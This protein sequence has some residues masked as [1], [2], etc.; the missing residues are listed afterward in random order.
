MLFERLPGR[1]QVRRSSPMPDAT[2]ADAPCSRREAL[3]RGAAILRDAGIERPRAEAR[4][5]LAHAAGVSADRLLATLDEAADW[6]AYAALVARRASREPAALILG[7]REFWSLSF[8]VSADT[9]IPRPDSESVVE[10]ALACAPD[11]AAAPRVLDL[12]TGTGCLLLS[13]LSERPNAWGVG[14]DLCPGAAALAA[15]NARSLGLA[16]RACFVCGDWAEPLNATFDVVL[17]NP[18]YIESAEIPGLMPEVAR[19]EPASA[20]DGGPDGLAAYRRVV[21]M[22]GR[23]LAPG[24]AA[25]LEVGAGQAEAVMRLGREEGHGAEARPDLAG[26]PRAVVLRRVPR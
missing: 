16:G 10:A 13:V 20:L 26:V 7:R 12:G 5:L 14:A 6:P 17:C 9:L 19:F 3:L 25:I 4:L 2:P 24:G 18:P 15:R 21:P 1:F 22:L 11:P 23:L 8:E